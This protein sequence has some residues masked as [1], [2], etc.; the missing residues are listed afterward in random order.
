MKD[1]KNKQCLW[2]GYQFDR[3]CNYLEDKDMDIV[4]KDYLS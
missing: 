4:V 2:D 1:I 3:I